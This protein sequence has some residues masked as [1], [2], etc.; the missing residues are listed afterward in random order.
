VRNALMQRPVAD[1]DIATPANPEQVMLACQAAG[2]KCIPTGLAHGT[3]TVISGHR[4]FE[5]TTLREDVET[6]GRHASVAF[7]DD[8]EADA[9]RRDFTMNALYCAAGGEVFDP[10]GGYPDLQA[11]RVRFIGDAAE[12]IREDYLRI[13][14]FFRF[15]AE[16]GDGAPD[17]DALHACVAECKG[18]VR[19]S[20]ERVRAELMKLLTAS[21]AVAAIE[22]MMDFGLLPLVLG[23]APRPALLSSLVLQER[24]FSVKPDAMLR[25]SALAVAV[26]EDIDRLADR[27]RL[28]RAERDALIVPDRR[29]IELAE[30]D[31]RTARRVLYEVGAEKWR[32]LIT[33]GAAADKQRS[34]RWA[35]LVTLPDRW[36]VPR[37]P[38]RGADAI[39]LGLE[40]G[41]EIGEALRALE[42]WWIESDFTAS[43]AELRTRLS[44]MVGKVTKN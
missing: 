29:L 18:L 36:T 5:V 6:F 17:R 43:E 2:L 33:A 11:A 12:R 19:L 37:F 21:G 13:L 26:E 8:W 15:Y 27:I 35:W 32:R 38:V 23:C 25:L 7:T 10:L 42:A 40:A 39:D 14:R 34:Q 41:P 44:E 3:I 9:R 31:D 28:S 4:P 20:A 1:I 22:T 24:T 16:Y 30:V